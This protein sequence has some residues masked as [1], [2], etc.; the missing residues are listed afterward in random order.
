MGW[1]GPDEPEPAGGAIGTRSILLISDGE[2][3]CGTPEP[4]GV[5]EELVRAGV[6]LRIDQL[7]ADGYRFAG[8]PVSRSVPGAWT[9]RYE[10]RPPSARCT[11][12]A[13]SAS[14]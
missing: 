8:R 3:N 13:T 11:P 10:S 12:R 5:A 1:R 9:N 7:A 2:G 6:G 14:R 4:C